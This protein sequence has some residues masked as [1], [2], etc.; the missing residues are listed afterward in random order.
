MADLRAEEPDY[1][2]M[3]RCARCPVDDPPPV[4]AGDTH[5]VETDSDGVTTLTDRY[6]EALHT[7]IEAKQENRQVPQAP[8]PTARPG[9]LKLVDLMAVLQESV[10][11]DHGPRPG[12]VVALAPRP[13]RPGWRRG[14]VGIGGRGSLS[15]GT[16]GTAASG[17]VCCGAG[18]T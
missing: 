7:V 12:G 13:A 10:G 15:R 3:E 11:K 17:S 14:A 4:D 18:A 5:T 6:T 9:Q 8:E 16:R 1:E 2:S